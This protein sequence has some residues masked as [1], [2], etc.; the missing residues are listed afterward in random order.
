[1]EKFIW[2][3]GSKAKGKYILIKSQQNMNSLLSS[4]PGGCS[5]IADFLIYINIDK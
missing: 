4:R 1:M 5:Q 3:R 2:D